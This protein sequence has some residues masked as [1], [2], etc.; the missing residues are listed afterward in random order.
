[1]Q[2]ALAQFQLKPGVTEKALLNASD[3][4]EAGFA[5]LQE[6]IL[7]RALV[8]NPNGAYADIVFFDSQEAM[9]RVMA[10]EQDDEVCARFMSLMEDDVE[11]IVYE[12][13][14]TYE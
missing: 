14:K 13:L 5:Q 11:V 6:G 10:A 4:F 2:I 9:E 12:V 8:R 3:E 7:R 1:M